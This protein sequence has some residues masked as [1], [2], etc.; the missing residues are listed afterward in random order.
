MDKLL[1]LGA[2]SFQLPL[3]QKAR[4]MGVYVVAITPEGNY[5]G[6]DEADKVYFHDAKDEKY[7]L[8]VA[9][10]ESVDGIISDQGEI[11]VKPIAYATGKL[12]LPGNRYE[13]AVIYTDKYK[14]REKARELGLPTIESIKV[15]TLEEAIQAFRKISGTAIIKPVDNSS[16][17]GIS[18]IPTEEELIAKFDEAKRYSR[19]GD[20]IVEKFI[21]G[22]QFEVDSIA[23]GGN[24]EPLMYADLQEF[25]IPN[26][27]SSMTRLYPSVA[28][29]KIIEKLLDYDRKINE[30]FGMIQ[31]ITH[32]EYILDEETG[33]IYL[34]EAALRGGGTFIATHIAKMQTGIDTSEFLVNVALGRIKDV[35]EFEMNQCHCGYVCCYLPH[36]EI[37]S[38]DGAGE[39]EDL[40]YVVKTNL[41]LFD[42][43]QKTEL[44]TD[45]NNRIA[46]VLYGDSRKEMLERIEEIRETLKIKV[47]TDKGDV[48]G[49][50]WE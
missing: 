10:K 6:I 45:K 43:G 15:R 42:V 22:P 7:A 37:I 39:V 44:I 35:P 26:V 20:L 36:G 9:K 3:I 23:A 25:K 30:G 13:T 31:G 29:D 21:E 50:I 32:N 38:M 33:E 27:F 8:E 48:R 34:I 14:M 12:G 47:K 5:P 18:K 49:P 16:S 28:D 4:E 11:F 17:R 1:V 46:I 41:N 24:I 19:G 2:G 40:S